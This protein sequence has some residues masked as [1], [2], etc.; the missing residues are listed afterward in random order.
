MLTDFLNLRLS[1]VGISVLQLSPTS[2]RWECTNVDQNAFVISFPILVSGVKPVYI[3]S[4]VKKK[5]KKLFLIGSYMPDANRSG[6]HTVLKSEIKFLVDQAGFS[7][8]SPE[9]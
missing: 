3:V 9:Q 1:L 8:V 7:K 4:E 2:L 6:G 5:K